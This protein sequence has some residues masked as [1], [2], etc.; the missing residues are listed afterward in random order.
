[1]ASRRETH[2]APGANY[3]KPQ[4]IRVC[5]PNVMLQDRRVYFCGVSDIVEPN[6]AWRAYKKELT[7]R[8]WDYDFRRLFFT[9]CDDI[10][11]EPFHEWVEIASREET[12]GWIQPADL[13][14]DQR[15]RV[16]IMWLERALDERLRAKFFPEAK[17][18][19]SLNYAIVQDGRILQR[20]VLL[21]VE[22]GREGM[23]PHF[24]RFHVS[25]A[26]RLFVLCYVTGQDTSGHAVSENRMFELLPGGSITDPVTV[27]LT[28]PFVNF[29]TATVRAGSPQSDTIDILGQPAGRSNTIAYAQIEL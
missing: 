1:M 25:K 20:Q 29:F 22:E 8:D 2:L 18:S 9:W 14:V 23:T 4:P 3:E 28:H 17:Q 12:C 21:V 27:P 6:S 16:H 15:Q 7:G 19:R 10:S 11:S 26:G 24:A 13:W 5:Y